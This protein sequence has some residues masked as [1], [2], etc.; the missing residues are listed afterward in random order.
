M[1]TQSV[2]VAKVGSGRVASIDMVRGLAMVVMALDHVRDFTCNIPFEPEDIEHTWTFYFLVRWVTHFCAPA[3]FLLAGTGAYLY[4]RK[5]SAGALEGFL[6]SRGAWLVVLEFTVIGFA[7]TFHP[8]WGM[9]GVICCL[10]LSMIL[11]AGFVRLP[12]WL[13]VAVALVVIAGHD[14][15]DGLKPA[16]FQSGAWLLTMLHSRGGAK[17]EWFPGGGRTIFV[18]FPLIPWCAV[19]LLGYGMGPLFEGKTATARRKLVYT[20]AGA[21][22]L[23]ALLRATNVYG[24]PSAELARST[25]GAWHVLPSLSKTVI[26]FFDVEKY[27]PSLDYLLMTLG[28]IFILLALGAARDWGWLG[29][30]L[31]IYGRVPLFFYILHLFTIHLAAIALGFLTH[32]P[33][34]WLF[35][36]GFFLNYP[37]DGQAYGHG[38]A[39]VCAVWLGVVMLLYFPCAWFAE[40]KRRHPDSLL[41]FL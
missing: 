7:W 3:F 20:G 12:R 38:L 30:A 37:P 8:G 27:P 35:H 1:Q 31:E 16:A 24:N 26:L 40:V 4:G 39:V 17:L 32:Q 2:S 36:G 41:R 25:P 6:V 18:L 28:V 21:L 9:F 23:F 10:G 15:F 19:T 29:R 22:V 34:R 11:L 14:L 33:V 5:H 13:V